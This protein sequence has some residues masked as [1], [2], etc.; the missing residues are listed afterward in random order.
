[1]VTGGGVAELARAGTEAATAGDTAV[2]DFCRAE[3]TRLFGTLR[4]YCGEVA[5]AEDL[6]QEALARLVRHWERVRMMDAPGAWLHR[7]AINLANSAF[8]RRMAERRAT[9]RIA[10]PTDRHED[11][12]SP[13]LLAVRAAVRA[14]PDRQRE[15]VIL[16][17]FH[18]LAVKATAD[19]MGCS[20]GNVKGLLSDAIRSL[21]AQ[22]LEVDPGE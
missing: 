20:E 19:R 14:L 1:M 11:P 10:S 18:D 6:A 21:R 2:D 3:Y 15:V 12:D 17:Y 22:G 9:G 16:R 8:R 7:V 13:T 5:L 4:L